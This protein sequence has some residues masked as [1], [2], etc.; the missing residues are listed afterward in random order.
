VD[1]WVLSPVV[2]FES[3]EDLLRKLP[4]KIISPTEKRIAIRQA[5]LK[6]LFG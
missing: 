1:E 3:T 4:E 5:K 2:E 6:E